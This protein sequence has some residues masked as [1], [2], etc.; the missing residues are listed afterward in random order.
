[1]EGIVLGKELIEGTIDGCELGS[2]LGIDDG[3]PVKVGDIL[4]WLLG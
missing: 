4:G 2:P 3:E 1:M